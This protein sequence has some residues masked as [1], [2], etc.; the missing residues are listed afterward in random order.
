MYR[1]AVAIRLEPMTEAHLGPLEELIRDRDVLRYTRVPDPPPDGFVHGWFARYEQ[2]RA[3]G[4]KE[5]FA[6]V[7][8]DGE[9]LGLA[10]APEIEPEARQAELGYMVMPS[11]RGRGVA[12]EATRLLTEWAFRDLGLER[13][14]LYISVENEPS[15]GVA[16]RCGYVLEGVLRSDYVKPGL[17]EDVEV[18]SRLPSDP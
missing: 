8:D 17:R 1:R 15:R 9:F 16:R 12:T 18:W 4:T 7:D 6:I 5:G 13:V 11:A 14:V 3:A 2:G 10:L